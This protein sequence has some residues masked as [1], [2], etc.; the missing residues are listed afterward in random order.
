MGILILATRNKHK[1]KE[2]TE[3]L[4]ID[5]IDIRSLI[6][7]PDIQEVV[8]DGLT[9]EQNALKKA[10]VIFEYTHSP[11]LSDDSGLE[12]MALGMRPGVWSARYAGTPVSYQQNNAK[13]L[14]EMS[15][16]PENKRQAQFKC[17]VVFKTKYFE[18]INTGI[19]GG[20]IVFKSKGGGGFG[21]DP[22]FMPSG[23]SQTFA[24]LSPI[25]KNIISHRAKALNALKTT[26]MHHYK[27]N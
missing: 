21:Y 7:Y 16:V 14:E 10:R 19:C 25:T 2:I 5:N 15:N 27:V 12:V 22:L 9:F 23:Y 1:V 11:T 20:K 18:K 6:D 17:V 26:L 24:E 8:E 13:L 3:I 4:S